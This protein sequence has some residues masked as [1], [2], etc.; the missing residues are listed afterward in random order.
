MAEI[1]YRSTMLG[2]EYLTY[3]EEWNSHEDK[4][5]RRLNAIASLR[6]EN[7]FESVVPI[8]RCYMSSVGHWKP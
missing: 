7:V 4:L 2:I 3:E 6:S 5:L 1:S 8:L